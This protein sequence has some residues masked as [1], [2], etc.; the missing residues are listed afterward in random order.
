[1]SE[2]QSVSPRSA[3]LGRRGEAM[4][5]QV[6]ALASGD[7]GGTA[8]GSRSTPVTPQRGSSSREALKQS[9]SYDWGLGGQQHDDRRHGM[10]LYTVSLLSS[11]AVRTTFKFLVTYFQIV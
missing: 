4:S 5:P 9:M 11:R 7:D 10:L 8:A 3:E 1:M 2:N 6:A